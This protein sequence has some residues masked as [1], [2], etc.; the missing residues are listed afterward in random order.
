MDCCLLQ[1]LLILGSYVKG[2]VT[3]FHL[4]SSPSVSLHVIGV[5]SGERT[6]SGVIFEC[7]P[8]S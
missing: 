3:L 1:C 5:N 6:S 4:H 8:F 2:T 7:L